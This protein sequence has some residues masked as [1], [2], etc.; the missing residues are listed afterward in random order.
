MTDATTI[1]TGQRFG[2]WQILSVEDKRRA[3]CRCRCGSTR[4]ISVDALENG[5]AARSCGCVRGPP[6]PRDLKERPG[7]RS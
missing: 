3:L 4:I 1:T 6:L 5:E 2:N 7:A